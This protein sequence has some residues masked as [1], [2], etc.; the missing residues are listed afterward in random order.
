MFREK[1]RL[2]EKGA[3]LILALL[4][5]LILNTL[6]IAIVMNSQID[7]AIS[8]NYSK[9]IRATFTAQTG[10]E[11]I[12]P[13]LLY[14]IQKDPNGWSNNIL[15]VPDGTAGALAGGTSSCPGVPATSDCFD[16][17]GAP[18]LQPYDIVNT[19]ADVQPTA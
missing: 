11:R 19:L 18:A 14:D 5:L 8:K 1:I 15:W 10:I 12:K 13:Y 6:V 17:T 7:N 2:N 9:T 16:L 3:T 4:F